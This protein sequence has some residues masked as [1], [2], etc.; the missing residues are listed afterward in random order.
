MF[1]RAKGVGHVTGLARTRHVV[2]ALYV[3][4]GP[5]RVLHQV[6]QTPP[7][8]DQGTGGGVT[9]DKDQDA[10]ARRPRA[11]DA[12]AAHGPHQLVVHRL[13]GTAQGQLAQSGQ[14]LGLEEIVLRQARGLRHIDLAG[15][16]PLAQLF[17]SQINQLD[18]VGFGKHLVRHPGSAAARR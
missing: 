15:R 13:G 4:H 7:R 5:G 3:S 16:Q 12:V 14:I 18:R 2:G 10:L 6:G 9:S 1:G 17:G 8:A 11:L